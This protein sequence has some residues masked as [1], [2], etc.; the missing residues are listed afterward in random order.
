MTFDSRQLVTTSFASVAIQR[1]MAPH[2][3]SS[4]ALSG[5]SLTIGCIEEVLKNVNGSQQTLIDWSAKTIGV[6]QG[7]CSHIFRVKLTWQGDDDTDDHRL[8]ASVVVKVPIEPKIIDC[9]DEVAKD[10]HMRSMTDDEM[11]KMCEMW[12]PYAHSNEI[13]SLTFLNDIHDEQLA[14][15]K[16]YF[17]QECRNDKPGH[18]YLIMEDVVRGTPPNIIEGLNEAQLLQASHT[19]A[20]I[21][22]TSI[23]EDQKLS[24]LIP[25]SDE[26]FISLFTT[27]EE[28]I[29][30][31]DMMAPDFGFKDLFSKGHDSAVDHRD[32]KLPL[33]QAATKK[34]GHKDR[35]TQLSHIEEPDTAASPR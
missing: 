28:V 9:K 21:H 35:H 30:Q 3:D 11:E 34:R 27:I 14:V 15:P 26:F 17:S 4:A 6:G 13:I 16:L 31:F 1:E 33:P 29:V 8:P 5:T 23:D 19:L 25:M 7:F 2:F 22:A 18:G 10:G 24:K 12:L 20:V 32:W